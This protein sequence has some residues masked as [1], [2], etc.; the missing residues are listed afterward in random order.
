[1]PGV[2]EHRVEDSAL[3]TQ[4]GEEGMPGDDVFLLLHADELR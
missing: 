4:V 3:F 2:L 1:V